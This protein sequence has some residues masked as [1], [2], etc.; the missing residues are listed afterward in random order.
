MERNVLATF[1]KAYRVQAFVFQK[2]CMK[3]RLLQLLDGCMV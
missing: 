1:K 2:I 3:E